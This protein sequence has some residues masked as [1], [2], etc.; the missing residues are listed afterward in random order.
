MAVAAI[1]VLLVLVDRLEDRSR[2]AA[3]AC[4]VLCAP[5]FWPGVVSEADLDARPINVV[6]GLGVLVGL[7]LTVGVGRVASRPAWSGVP[8]GDRARLA[9]TVLATL[10]ALPWIAAELGL[11]LDN[12]PLLGWLFQTG[13]HYPSAASPAAVHHGHHHGMDGLLLLITA[14]LLSRLVPTVRARGL[15]V[16]LGAYLSLMTAYA[17]GN[18]ANDFWTEQVWKREWTSWKIPSVLEPKASVAWGLIVLGAAALYVGAARWGSRPG[19][20]ESEVVPVHV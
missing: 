5:V 11:F 16:F 9:I 4:V 3:A 14:L 20:G 7:V 6:A 8:T 17:I 15:R 19:R 18:F 2:L 1:A 13:H 10:L 12:V